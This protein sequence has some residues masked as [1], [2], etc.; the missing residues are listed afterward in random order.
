ML[1]YTTVRI[2]RFNVLL[3][4]F[5]NSGYDRSI[6]ATSI[7][8]MEKYRKY[9]ICVFSL[10]IFISAYSNDIANNDIA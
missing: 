6:Q 1:R 4:T 7:I 8:K 3:I 10:A 9:N 5:I 2:S